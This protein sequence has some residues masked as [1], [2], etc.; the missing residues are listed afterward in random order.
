MPAPIRPM[1]AIL[2]LTLAACR[3]TT[4]RD[5]AD[6]VV[7]ASDVAPDA[8]PPVACVIDE[9][10]HTAPC[11]DDV[12][13]TQALLSHMPGPWP[14]AK[15]VLGHFSTPA[16][17]GSQLRESWFMD[18][19]F[20]RLHDEW[21]W[22]RLLN[23]RAID[24]VPEVPRTGEALPT[25]D[26]V[27]AWARE[28]V[29]LPYGLQ[30]IENRLYATHF[31]DLGFGICN[32]APCPRL[33]G[34]AS[35]FYLPP[36]PKR[37][38]PEGIYG[39]ALEYGDRPT[40]VEIEH[41]FAR[42]EA[43]LPPEIAQQLRWIGG[44]APFQN[45]LAQTIRESSS[46]LATRVLTWA[47][48]IADGEVVG[49]TRG[50]TAGRV[51]KVAA[52][53]A[54]STIFAATD[55]VVL[56]DVPTA[57]PPVAGILTALPQTPQAHL[58][59]LAAARG[60]PNAYSSGAFSDEIL[61]GWNDVHRAVVWEVQAAALRWKVMTSEQWNA[62]LKLITPLPTQITAIDLVAA[63][64]TY[65]L[66]QGD[67]A[68]SRKLV[69]LLGGKC[70]GL[71]ALG[72][73]K[74]VATPP[75]IFCLTV[76][77][78]AQH[79][80]S[81]KPLIAQL[82]ADPQFTSD[83]SS[84]QLLLEGYDAYAQR[85]A[86]DAIAMDTWNYFHD[87]L[88]QGAVKTVLDGGGLRTLVAQKPL[89][90][91]YEAEILAA[92]KARFTELS[93]QQALRFRSS[94]TAEDIEGFNGAGVY[95]S[96]SGF[97]Y[98]EQ[99]TP[100]TGKIRSASEAIRD[101]WASYWLGD[102]F[103]E[104]ELAHIDHLSGLMAVAVHPR[105]DDDAESANG[106]ALVAYAQRVDGDRLQLT[107]D[108][109]PGALSVTNPPAGMDNL[110]EIDRV[111]QIADKPPQVQRLQP[112]TIQKTNVLSDE[113]LL[114]M[115][116]QTSVL[117]KAWLIAKQAPLQAEE[118]PQ[119]LTLDLEFR[120]VHPGWPMLADKT[121]QPARLVWKQVRPLEH[122]GTLATETLGGALV[123]RDVLHA[124]TSASLRV[125]HLPGLNVVLTEVLTDP[126]GPE[127][128]GVAMTDFAVKP[129]TA[130]G[131]LNFLQEVAGI[132]AG[133][134]QDATWLQVV[135]THPNTTSKHWDV[136]LTAVQDLG[137]QH[138]AIDENGAWQFGTLSGTDAQCV[139]KSL[140]TSKEAWLRAILDSP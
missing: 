9:A 111:L 36:N 48:L 107:V 30:W 28:Q 66:Q 8:D 123:P 20:Y 2:L 27:Y 68:T 34:I 29:T 124:A 90:P 105:F 35:L 41:F 15:L 19:G 100:G 136:A 135:A 115:F 103:E 69:P 33:F 91:A 42:I 114:L 44:P 51:R 75:D 57:L 37:A 21:Y 46:P 38:T 67:V 99:Q 60:T 74:G 78:Y 113:E 7:D 106:V 85:H 93:P 92:L 32:N 40:V 22:F 104:R 73:Q 126:T 116:A 98:P 97:L 5:E 16:P 65:D 112:A 131:Q 134:Q 47:D 59:L 13:A 64:T 39:F 18:A 127:I 110:P 53:K 31:Y 83:P 43:M 72:A 61:D 77:G 121:V 17:T 133:T 101:V 76:K 139:G 14:A 129:F 70:A 86:G 80:A 102:A 108:V 26:A 82:L 118:Q 23:G 45:A 95:I 58:N 3:A 50:I 4:P 71:M 25:I 140:Q 119:S 120:R 52:G 84:R 88:W 125:C 6:A 109:Q 63:P 56:A 11:F 137:W 62:W 94:S 128:A 132:P 54:D 81:L 12:T 10:M 1:L 79:I 89:D 87:N 138:L 117:T 55:L 122:V 96:E 130:R 24:G 49:Y